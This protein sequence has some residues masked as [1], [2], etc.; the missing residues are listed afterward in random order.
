ML[1]INLIS[2]ENRNYNIL[3][4]IITYK[5]RKCDRQTAHMF[6]LSRN[7]DNCD[8]KSKPKFVLSFTT[9]QKVLFKLKAQEI[10]KEC[11]TEIPYCTL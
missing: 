11:N 8:K 10:E 5:K 3:N 9:K 2:I 4:K 6:Y 7:F 1:L